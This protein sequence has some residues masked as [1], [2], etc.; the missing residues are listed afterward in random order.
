MSIGKNKAREEKN[1]LTKP[2]STRTIAN[3]NKESPNKTMSIL[4][5]KNNESQTKK[6]YFTY[7]EKK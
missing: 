1:Y 3:I 5:N 4:D 2:A 6:M 7:I